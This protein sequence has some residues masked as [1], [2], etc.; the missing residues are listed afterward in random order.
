MSRTTTQVH[1]GQIW[2]AVGR[3]NAKPFEILGTSADEKDPDY[4]RVRT[5]GV[6]SRIGRPVRLDRFNGK[7]GGYELV[8]YE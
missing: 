1:R 2:K 3:K 7:S 5:V 6:K 4:V 8:S